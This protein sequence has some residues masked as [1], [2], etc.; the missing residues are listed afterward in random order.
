MRP[1]GRPVFP[2]VATAFTLVELLVAMVVTLLLVVVLAQVFNGTATTWRHSEAQV[3]AYREARGALQLMARDLSATLEA[4]YA[5]AGGGADPATAVTVGP[6]V[7]TLVLQHNPNSA[8][9]KTYPDGPNNEEVYCLTNIP[10]S[11]TSSPGLC[12]VG[13]FCAWMPD[14][15][16]SIQPSQAPHA[17]AL[18]RQSLDSNGTFQRLKLSGGGSTPM[19]FTSLFSQ[20]G[21]PQASVTQLAAYVWDLRF[22]IDTDLS[23][24]NTPDGN[25]TASPGP[26]DHSSPFPPG[27]VYNGTGGP[28]PPRLPPYIEIRFRALSDNAARQLEGSNSAANQSTWADTGAGFTPAGIY[29]QVILPN[30]QQFVLRVPFTNATPLPTPVP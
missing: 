7:P 16:P 12:A 14:K 11:G 21:T 3:D 10:N 2:S 6:L 1:R 25:A 28:Y 23:E 20:A 26:I 29:K 8:E 5:Q 18:M 24:T 13:Y 17:Y 15:D 4:S 19:V 30:C 27:R 9:V 22:R